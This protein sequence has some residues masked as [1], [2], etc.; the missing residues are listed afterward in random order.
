MYILSTIVVTLVA[1]QFIYI[2]RGLAKLEGRLDH[3]E[4]LRNPYKK[5]KKVS[6]LKSL[7]PKGN[8]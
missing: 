3:L 2:L 8:K 1:S 7:K 4:R 5:A 6:I